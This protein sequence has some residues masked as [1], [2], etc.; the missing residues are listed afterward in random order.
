MRAIG[1]TI[2]NLDKELEMQR[3]SSRMSDKNRVLTNEITSYLS[4]DKTPFLETQL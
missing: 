3:K 4:L 2:R 1:Y